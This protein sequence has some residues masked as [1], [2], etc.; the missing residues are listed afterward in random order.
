MG[1]KFHGMARA[2]VPFLAGSMRM[3]QKTFLISN[4]IASIFWTTAMV[5]LGVVF[6][7]YYEIVIKYIRYIVLG[8]MVCGTLY[9]Y[10]FKRAALKQYMADKEAEIDKKMS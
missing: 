8:L 10:F 9:V 2:F 4:I 1:S 7:Q 6:V 3:S 5:V